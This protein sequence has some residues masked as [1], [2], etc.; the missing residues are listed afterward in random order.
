MQLLHLPYKH[1]SRSNLCCISQIIQDYPNAYFDNDLIDLGHLS[2]VGCIVSTS[3]NQCRS[4]FLKKYL[5]PGPSRAGWGASPS[6]PGESWE[7]RK[8]SKKHKLDIELCMW[9]NENN[10]LEVPQNQLS[11]CKTDWIVV[12]SFFENTHKFDLDLR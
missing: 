11:H 1:K 6:S 10:N 5:F 9:N 3:K 8:T 4:S 7:K 2:I 12:D